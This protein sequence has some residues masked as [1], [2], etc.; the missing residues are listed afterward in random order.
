M[1]ARTSWRLPWRFSTSPVILPRPARHVEPGLRVEV[2]GGE[3]SPLDAADRSV[4]RL[5]RVVRFDVLGVFSPG[6]MGLR[7]RDIVMCGSPSVRV[8]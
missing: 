4:G 3:V 8:E 7:V 5:G 1:M 2:R 6:A